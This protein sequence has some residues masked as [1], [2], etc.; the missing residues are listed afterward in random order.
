[1]NGSN[2]SAEYNATSNSNNNISSK[3]GN[4]N[5]AESSSSNS[6]TT[7]TLSGNSSGVTLMPSAVPLV[8]SPTSSSSS[9]AAVTMIPLIQ[10]PMAKVVIRAPGTPGTSSPTSAVVSDGVGSS[11]GSTGAP[12][13]VVNTDHVPFSETLEG[14]P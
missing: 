5:T 10:E 13:V 8:S 11:H 7:L 2:V 14:F 12:V 6:L 9:E 1:L 4:T 3:A